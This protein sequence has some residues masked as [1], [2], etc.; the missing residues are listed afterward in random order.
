MTPIFASDVENSFDDFGRSG[1]SGEA[2][3]TNNYVKYSA[4]LPKRQPKIQFGQKGVCQALRKE[5]AEQS[6]TKSC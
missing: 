1:Y 2:N 6:L 5:R 4:R 3:C